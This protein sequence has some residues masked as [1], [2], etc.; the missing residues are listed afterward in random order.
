MTAGDHAGARTRLLVVQPTGFCNIDCRYCYLRDRNNTARMQASQAEAMFRGL[1]RLPTVREE[2]TVVWHAGEPLTIP[3]NE[4]RALLECANRAAPEGLIVRHSIQTNGTL[5]DERWCE[6]FKD[7]RIGIGLSIDGPKAINDSMRRAR[8]GAGTFDRAMR[9]LALL[10]EHG[11]PF[12]VISVLTDAALGEPDAMFAFYDSAQVR[13]IAFNIEEREGTHEVSSLDRP[14]SLTRYKAFLIRF[15]ELARSAGV[16]MDI[17]ELE[18]T[19]RSIH[20]WSP[21]ERRLN[22]QT[23]PFGIVSMDLSGNLS[24]FSPELLGQLDARY[25]NFRIGNVLTDT[26]EELCKSA[27]F[28]AMWREIEAGVAACEASCRYFHVCGGG[29]PSNKLY[30]NGTFASTATS[31]C[32]FSTMVPTDLVLALADGVRGESA[33]Q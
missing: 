20:A 23:Q 10:Q 33:S 8:N 15:L 7:F 2:V 32:R 24:T 17:R 31:Y 25:D 11:I 4:F 26:F 16:A 29:A 22:E 21:G 6:L 12:H 13:R 1:F 9:G 3:A 14:D 30:E 28:T 19:L 5:I 27:G 18:S